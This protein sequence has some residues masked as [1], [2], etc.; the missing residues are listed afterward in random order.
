M[1]DEIIKQSFDF[2]NSVAP[3]VALG[4]SAEAA[5]I[6]VTWLKRA[7]I[8]IALEKIITILIRILE[9]PAYLGGLFIIVMYYPDTLQWLLMQIG[10]I[11]LKIFAI[12]LNAFLPDIFTISASEVNSWTTIFNEG[13]NALPT[14]V[15]DVMAKANV[16]ELMGM[17]TSALSAAFAI[18]LYFRIMNRTTS[19]I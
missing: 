12:I 8:L 4:L 7:G 19:F 14:D 17:V 1:N 15:V 16:A 2:S 9:K 10:L 13:I 3:L 5:Q 11:E 18:R 6:L